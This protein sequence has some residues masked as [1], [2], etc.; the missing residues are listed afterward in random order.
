MEE[1]YVSWNTKIDQNLDYSCHQTLLQFVQIQPP[2]LFTSPGNNSYLKQIMQMKHNFNKKT[3]S[4]CRWHSQKQSTV[5][6]VPEVQDGLPDFMTFSSHKLDTLQT[7]ELEFMYSVIMQA[8][9]PV[10]SGSADHRIN[11]LDPF[12]VQ[13]VLQNIKGLPEEKHP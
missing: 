5:L 2:Q 12:K 3:E 6:M 13:Q 4:E 10:I 7:E 11:L 8:L 9:R 1:S